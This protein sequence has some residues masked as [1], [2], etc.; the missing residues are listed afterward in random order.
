MRYV[1]QIGFVHGV[2][3]NVFDHIAFVY[4]SYHVELME[5]EKN[6]IK[7]SSLAPFINVLCHAQIDRRVS[8]CLPI[9]NPAVWLRM[10]IQFSF[11]KP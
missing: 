11:N 7:C 3:I 4:P 10:R 9:L 5:I 6:K 2:V 1:H 8:G